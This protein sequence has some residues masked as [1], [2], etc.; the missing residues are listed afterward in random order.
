[1]KIVAHRSEMGQGIRTALPMVVADEMEADF[2]KVQVVQ[3]PGDTRYGS[4]DTDGS[5]SIR[6]FFE[7][8]RRVGA[9]ARS[10]LVSAAAKS[11]GVPASE[12]EAK[13]HRVHHKASG[14][15][16]GYGE[17]AE[18]AAAEPVPDKGTLALKTRAGVALHRQG[19]RARRPLRTS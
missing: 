16:L 17:L 1:M 19:P 6:D 10:M 2:D 7:P 4:Q 12:C 15:S 13:L 3:A 5:H 14:R 18:R 8:M 11:W 9:S